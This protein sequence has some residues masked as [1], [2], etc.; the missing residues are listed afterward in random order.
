VQNGTMLL[1]L[2]LEKTGQV[3]TGL[4]IKQTFSRIA[5]GGGAY[6]HTIL[7]LYKTILSNI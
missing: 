5:R 2:E 3:G 1:F 7:F 4:G 6:V